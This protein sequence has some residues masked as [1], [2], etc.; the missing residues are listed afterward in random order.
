MTKIVK[1]NLETNTVVCGVV[2]RPVMLHPKTHSKY[3]FFIIV[4]IFNG[5]SIEF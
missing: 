5:S 2:A 4:I 1:K 3:F